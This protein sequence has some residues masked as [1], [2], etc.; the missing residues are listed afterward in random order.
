MTIID[1]FQIK[2]THTNQELDLASLNA[3]LKNQ[4]SNNYQG[5]TVI[6]AQ[7]KAA[8]LLTRLLQGQSTRQLF[9]KQKLAYID[10]II[11]SNSVNLLYFGATNNTQQAPTFNSNKLNLA[12]QR[13]IAN[14]TYKDFE[15]KLQPLDEVDD[16]ELVTNMALCDKTLSKIINNVLE[17]KN[18][19]KYLLQS[20]LRNGTGVL[21]TSILEKPKKDKR[22]KTKHT[23]V[24]EFLDLRGLYLDEYA[25]DKETLTY[26]FYV[27][28]VNKSYAI[29]KYRNLLS[30][31]LLAII[32][33]GTQFSPVQT[34]GYYSITNIDYYA[35]L[36]ITTL[37]SPI[38]ENT[39]A[40]C[41]DITRFW[42]KDN[43]GK[44]WEY[45]LL[46]QFVIS[47][48][49]LLGL[50]NLPLDFIYELKEKEAIWGQSTIERLVPLQ[51]KLDTWHSA[52]TDQKLRF[53]NP[54]LWVDIKL[55]ISQEALKK[56]IGKG[57]IFRY[58]NTQ[59]ADI[60][61][62]VTPI[63]PDDVT[64][65][66]LQFLNYY[67]NLIDTAIGVDGVYNGETTKS[68]GNNATSMG[69]LYGRV[70]ALDKN[71]LEE[72][73]QFV[74]NLSDTVLDYLKGYKNQ[75]NYKQIVGVFDFDTQEYKDGVKYLQ[76]LLTTSD[77]KVEFSVEPSSAIDKANQIQIAIQLCSM[78]QEDGVSPVLP[79]VNLLRLV[80]LPE[81]DSVIEN[82]LQNQGADLTSK[83][84]LMVQVVVAYMHNKT[85]SNNST[86]TGDTALVS[87]LMQI[88]KT[89]WSITSKQLTQ[90]ENNNNQ[91]QNAA[92]G[93]NAGLQPNSIKQGGLNNA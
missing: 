27:S 67:S 33:A 62:M 29:S 75:I 71:I 43:E 1:N 41:C 39:F 12:L 4:T 6:E 51:E 86:D 48:K 2:D 25:S 77:L 59:N 42:E 58:S 81:T 82:M 92:N 32:N 22:T 57:S 35:Q 38:V 54:D 8:K 21:Y 91:M 60:R 3:Q 87:Q 85:D 31:D 90:N 9:Y 26:A 46:G 52:L 61:S 65:D 73:K 7:Q 44:I 30:D 78:K 14:N 36:Y 45:L 11:T 64:E 20:Q 66:S 53:T 56:G 28:R 16:P 50:K 80:N 49:Q 34:S 84:S 69:M 37:R 24:S 88:W 70:T 89:P 10:S 15:L 18:N 76:T 23:I 83:L 19:T 47:S 5:K 72:W 55:G 68:A 63:R 74:K 93:G 17:H 13:K 40:Q 79:F